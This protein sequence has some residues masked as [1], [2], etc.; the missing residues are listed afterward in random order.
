MGVTLNLLQSLGFIVN[1]QKS[2]LAPAQS[3]KFLGLVWN[4]MTGFV[5]ID[6]QKRSAM[7]TKAAA[8]A[9]SPQ[10]SCRALFKLLGHMSACLLAVPL[11]RLHCRYLQRDLKAVYTL[12]HHINRKVV[13]SPEGR[14]D[15]CWTASLEPRHCK[16]KMWNLLLEDCDLEV[17]TDAS[18]IAWGVYFQGQMHHGFWE[19]TNVDAQAHINVKELAALEV[20]LTVY[21]PQS[22]NGCKLLWRTDNT[23]ALSYIRREGGTIS[24]HLL[25]IARRIL[26]HRRQ[27]EI[28]PV[29]ISSEENLQADAASRLQSIPDWRLPRVFRQT[30]QHLGNAGNRLVRDKRV[31]TSE[32][33]LRLEQ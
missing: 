8:M 7:T 23:T 26:L 19:S 9:T 30:D 32:S 10:T 15:L 18:D 31:N 24:L 29:Y 2:S 17:S 3:F 6:D 20:F 5:S 16:K 22:A 25:E 4:T 11:L 21:L 1:F 14:R 27:I 28:L 13:I 33:V 12:P